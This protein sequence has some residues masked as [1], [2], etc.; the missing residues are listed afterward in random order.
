MEISFGNY[1]FKDKKVN[2]RFSKKFFNT[3]FILPAPN[4]FTEYNS[5]TKLFRKDLSIEGKM[6]SPQKAIFIFDLIR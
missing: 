1:I 5:T 2:I 3:I 4:A 6:K